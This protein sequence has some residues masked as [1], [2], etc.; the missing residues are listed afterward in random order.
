LR[1]IR[2]AQVKNS[3]ILLIFAS[4]FYGTAAVSEI[5]IPTLDIAD[6][7]QRQV[8]IA[9]G[10]ETVYQGHPTTELLEDG[11]TMYCVWTRDHGGACGP[12]KRSDD[13][14]L[15]WSEELPVPD[16]WREARNCPAI[17]RVTGPDSVERLIVFAMQDGGPV[18][19]GTMTQSIS[20]DGGKSWSAMASNGLTGVVMPFTTVV[21]VDD[22][23]RLLGMTNNRR[24]GATEKFTNV[25]TQS[26]SDDGGLTWSPLKVVVDIQDRIPCEPCVVRSP[27]GS[28][29]L[30]L[31]RENNRDKNALMMTSNDEGRSWSEPIELPDA[32]SGDRHQA[33]YTGDGRLVVAFR[34]TARNSPTKDHFVAWVGRY[35][36]IVEGREGQYRVKLLHSYKGSDCGYPGMEVLPD[37]TI[38]AT[39]YV[40]YRPGPE[41]IP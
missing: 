17:Y 28:Q 8:V 34:D 13:G 3:T 37:E 24:P 1:N 31:I 30:C 32:L 36:D 6:E 26:F 4:V 20:T 14:G 19:G 25:V 22:G 40:K 18:E 38:V 23:K 2:E 21:P 11:Q 16:S 12:M 27:D 29:L 33:V 5:T 35:E 10:T 7:T 9:A 39:T 41:K 15:T